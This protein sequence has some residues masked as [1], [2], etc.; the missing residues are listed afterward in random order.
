MFSV[1]LC[2]DQ[3]SQYRS[4]K[5]CRSLPEET[6]M[7]KKSVPMLLWLASFKEL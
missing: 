5:E 1:E 7:K 3:L 2:K 4:A 6:L